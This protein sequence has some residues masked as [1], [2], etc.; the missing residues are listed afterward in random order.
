MRLESLAV[1]DAPPIKFFE[2]SSLADVVVVAGPNG[3]GKSRLLQRLILHLRGGGGEGTAQ[4]RIAATR[5]EEESAWGQALLD[6]NVGNDLTRFR[7]TLQTGRRR[8]RWTS[9]LVYFESDR[10]IQNLKP[11]QFS[12]DMP[13]PDEEVVGWETTFGFL[14]DRFQDTLHAM[15]RM[16]EAQKQSIANRAIQLQRQGHTEMKLEFGDPMAQFKSVFSMLLAP[17]ELVDPSAK[18]QRLRYRE[19]GVEREFET[20]SSGEREVVN[21]G[22]DFLLRPPEDCIIFFDEPE[23]HLHPELSY[24]LLQT[25]RAIGSR[26]QFVLST[27]SPDIITA[28]L[29]QSVIFLS[30]PR[31]DANGAAANQAISV[32][33]GDETNQALRL[34]GQSIGIIALGRRIVLIEGDRASLDKQTYGAI[35]RHR[36]PGLV[37]VPSGGKQVLASFET[38]LGSVLERTIWGVDFRML[39]DGDSTPRHSPSVERAEREGRLRVLPRYHLENYFLDEFVWAEAFAP[40]E[41]DDSWLRDPSRIRQALRELAGPVVSYAASLAAQN[42][43]RLLVGNVDVMPKDCSGKTLAEVQRLVGHRAADEVA[44]IGSALDPAVVTAVVERAYSAIA[45]ALEDD[46]D[47]WKALVPGRPLLNSFAAK[48]GLRP[49]RAKNLY[50]NA[51]TSSTRRPFAEVEAIFDDFTRESLP[52][53][54]R[55]TSIEAVN[56]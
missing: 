14:R 45:R 38:V 26:N 48:T 34:L 41:R 25:L 6:L 55:P 21:I 18:D 31:V 19:E 2:A 27:H 11:L 15:F 43:L 12:W 33:E 52:A 8:Q 37:L 46:D 49:A 53:T 22:F 30:A 29:D 10:S 50:L 47:A 44:R 51:A 35:L 1:R 4:V 56:V 24:K 23:L 32:A 54:T 5:P 7:Q 17:K 16:I 3:V 39:C 36:H 28:S 13:N 42:E 40:M 20:L 9:S